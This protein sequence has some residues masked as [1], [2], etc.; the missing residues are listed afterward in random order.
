MQL[1]LDPARK[2]IRVSGRGEFADPVLRKK[3][4]RG[5]TRQRGNGQQAERGPPGNHN[6]AGPATA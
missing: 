4:R 5:E 6:P 3:A 1:S 2:A